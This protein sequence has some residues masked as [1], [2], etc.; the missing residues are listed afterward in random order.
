MAV[1]RCQNDL[2]LTRRMGNFRVFSSLNCAEKLMR[3]WA[4]ASEIRCMQE[5]CACEGGLRSRSRS[6]GRN[7]SR[8]QPPHDCAWVRWVFV[9]SCGRCG[10]L[11]QLCRPKTLQASPQRR[12]R[13][14]RFPAHHITVPRQLMHCTALWLSKAWKQIWDMGWGLEIRLF[15]S[16]FVKLYRISQISGMWT[17][18]LW[19]NG[20]LIAMQVC[21]DPHVA[22]VLNPQT[23]CGAFVLWLC[24][25]QTPKPLTPAYDGKVVR[26]ADGVIDKQRD[27]FITVRE[28]H[29]FS[30]ST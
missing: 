12:Y 11:L 29:V 30:K 23:L 15:R 10:L 25:D 2:S 16:M 3:V 28:G 7:T 6:S 24:A 1:D 21:E 9:H 13:L 14:G 18:R 17:R 27:R 26:Y 5:V 20:V 22:V 19:K 4:N 8:F